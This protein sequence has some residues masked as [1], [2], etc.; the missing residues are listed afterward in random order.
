MELPEDVLHIIRG[1]SKPRMRFYKEYRKGLTELGFSQDEHWNAL[2][3]KLCTTDAD[4]VYH[5]FLIY[6]NATLAVSRF[7]DLPWK[8]PYSIYHAELQHLIL[9]RDQI[10]RAFRVLLVGEERVLNHERW[11][12]Y[13]LEDGDFD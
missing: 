9:I 11:A 5:A 6:K 2:R 13:E 3:E 4:L 10:D 8:G 12:R 7:H 1:F